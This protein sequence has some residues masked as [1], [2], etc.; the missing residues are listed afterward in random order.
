MTLP[1]WVAVW[2]VLSIPVSIVAGSLLRRISKA[3]AGSDGDQDTHQERDQ[4]SSASARWPSRLGW[5]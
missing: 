2:L 1:R 5:K 3:Q 4:V